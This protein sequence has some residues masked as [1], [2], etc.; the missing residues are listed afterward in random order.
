MITLYEQNQEKYEDTTGLCEIIPKDRPIFRTLKKQHE[1][2]SAKCFSV[3][4]N[5]EIQQYQF[6]TSYFIGVDWI[7]ENKC[8]IYVQ[9]K[10]NKDKREINHI[11]MLLDAL[12]EP[13]NFSHLEGLCEIDFDRP[14]IEITQ[15]QDKLSPFLVAQFLQLLKHI[16]QK[17]LKRSYY[18]ISEN[19]NA[20][21]KG[22]VLIE[23]DIKTN[24]FNGNPISTMCQFQEFGINCDENKILKKAYKF[25]RRVIQSYGKGIDTKAINH[26]IDY[27]SPAFENVSDDIDIAKIKSFKSNPLF[28]EYGTALKLAKLILRRY[29]YNITL[30]EQQNILTPPFWIDMSKLFELYVYK[31][32]RDI[33]RKEQ[34]I[35]HPRI[36]QNQEPDFLI[37]GYGECKFVVDA[38]YKPRYKDSTVHYD[39]IRQ[40]SGYARTKNVYDKLGI[41]DKDKSIKCVIIYSHQD[42][43][44]K[45]FEGKSFIPKQDEKNNGLLDEERGYVNIFKVGINLP[46]IQS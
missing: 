33:F 11:D 45:S 20:R 7:V 43:P 34:I 13:E 5:D 39:D 29:S 25:S 15:A 8:S 2:N 17:G 10:Q 46:E 40:V 35:Y 23:R 42:C 1:S 30:T 16:V 24:K 32:L 18:T 31:K 37:N 9:P 22:K 12:Q 28:Q 21:I 44:V 41:T 27:I 36:V 4:Y 6:Q 26:I 3:C 19:L 14:Y 38:K